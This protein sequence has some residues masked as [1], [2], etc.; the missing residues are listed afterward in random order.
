MRTYEIRRGNMTGNLIT[1]VEA[2]TYEGAASKAAGATAVKKAF[3]FSPHASLGTNRETGT[4]GR[5]GVFSLR[6]RGGHAG[7]IHVTSANGAPDSGH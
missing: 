1:T 7:E 2:D 5:S 4:V 6:N 3:G